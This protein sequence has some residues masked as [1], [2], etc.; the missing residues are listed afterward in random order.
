MRKI[1]E[2]IRFLTIEQWREIEKQYPGKREFDLKAALVMV[3]STVILITNEYFGKSNFIRDHAGDLFNR[4]PFP[5]LYPHLY[6]SL[7]SSFTYFVPP[8]L[9]I[10][11]VYKEKIKDYGFH[12]P[13]SHKVHALYVAMFFIVLPLVYM[14]S[15]SRSFQDM[16]PFYPQAG[17]S[18]AEFFLWETGY[19]FQF[20]FLEFFFRGFLLFALARYVGAYAIFFMAVP[21]SMI[22][23][24][25]PVLETFGAIIAGTALGTLALRTRSIYGGV[26][27]HMTI[28]WSMDICALL[29]KGILKKLF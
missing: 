29:Q 14:V 19:G 12:W 8:L 4:L 10:L 2:L 18:L 26:I 24:G 21:Y 16:Y 11:F 23:F 15:F 1:T 9:V 13:E 5:G 27:V 25:K 3:L 17:N 22:H 7:F 20:L 28:A 6:W